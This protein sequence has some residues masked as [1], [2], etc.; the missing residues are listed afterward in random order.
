MSDLLL[1]RMNNKLNFMRNPRFDK[2]K[3]GGK[4]GGGAHGLGNNVGDVST[5]TTATLP[6]Q[7]NGFYGGPRKIQFTDYEVGKEYETT[8]LFRNVTPVS[9]RLRLLPPRSEHFAMALVEFPWR[10]WP[11]C[12]WD[13]STFDSA[14][15][16]RLIGRLPRC[17]NLHH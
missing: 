1:Q 16:A 10:G 2:N 7:T 9:R 14:L 3:Y 5:C 4:S 6:N 12:F 8:V 11:G 17:F 13:V 15:S